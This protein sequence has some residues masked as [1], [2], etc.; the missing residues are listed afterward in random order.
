MSWDMDAMIENTAGTATAFAPAQ[1]KESAHGHSVFKDV[2]NTRKIKDTIGGKIIHFG[3]YYGLGFVVNNVLTEAF[4]Y[5]FNTKEAAKKIRDSATSA[6]ADTFI[7]MPP[8]DVHEVKPWNEQLRA[9]L[10]PSLNADEPKK[11]FGAMARMWLHDQVR[12]TT[13]I[14]FMMVAGWTVTLFMGSLAKRQEDI[15]YWINQKLGK[16]TDVLTEKMKLE[17]YTPESTQDIIEFEIRKRINESQTGGDI[18]KARFIGAA[19]VILGDMALNTIG[20]IGEK[21]GKNYLSV[22]YMAARAAQW[23]CNTGIMPAGVAESLYN[24]YEKIGAKLEH[25][26]NNQPGNYARLAAIQINH[27]GDHA[28]TAEEMLAQDLQDVHKHRMVIG[29][30]F[31]ITVKDV[32]WTFAMAKMLESMA[33]SFTKSRVIKER[34]KAIADIKNSLFVVNGKTYIAS[35]RDGHAYEI[36]NESFDALLNSA[37]DKKEP[38]PTETA[39]TVGVSYEQTPAFTEGSKRWTKKTGKR[40]ELL[41]K[42]TAATAVE[43]INLS[44]AD[45]VGVSI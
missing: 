38:A 19:I 27:G 28:V 45:T 35:S 9:R 39:K 21:M 16:D 33:Q 11:S 15:G 10:D 32:G 5:W 13:E 22:D 34:R 44:Q 36:P 8:E 7:R 25:T 41:A 20:Q 17:R 6:I 14:L 31:R 40:E 42:E 4:T 37:S 3:L 23:L 2:K 43:R 29:E 12:S 18:W 1:E 30:Q 24:F 26:K